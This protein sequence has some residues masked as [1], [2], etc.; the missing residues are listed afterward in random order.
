MQI[1]YTSVMVE[2]Q[3]RALN[4][5]TDLLGFTKVAD[6]PAG[7]YRWLTVTSPEGPEGVEAL[8]RANGVPASA[9]VPEGTVRCW[10]ACHG[11]RHGRHPRRLHAPEVS[12]RRVPE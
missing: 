7:E 6:V 8:A 11:L 10:H 12:G 1:K 5:Y 4:F 9:G 3:E 2:D